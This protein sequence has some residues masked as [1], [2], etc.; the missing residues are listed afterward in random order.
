MIGLAPGTKVFLACQPIDL[1]AAFDGLSAK[2]QQII[3]ADPFSGRAR[4]KTQELIERD[5]ETA[6]LGKPSAPRPAIGER[7]R[8]QHRAP[9]LRDVES[10]QI[11]ARP[12]FH[13]AMIGTGRRQ[14]REMA[15]SQ[16]ARLRIA[17]ARASAANDIG[18]PLFA[19]DLSAL[20]VGR[21]LDPLFARQVADQLTAHDTIGADARD[22]HGISKILDG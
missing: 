11:L 12:V 21:G 1:R 14:S 6:T 8:P 15:R 16:P 10:G 4:I 7:H 2:V 13:R 20:Y 18:S 3:G 9:R 5:L 22:E 19:V 17:P